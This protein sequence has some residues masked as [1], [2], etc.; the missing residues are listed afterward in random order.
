MSDT[1]VLKPNSTP[2][3][4]KKTLPSGGQGVDVDT[5]NRQMAPRPWLTIPLSRRGG[6]KRPIGVDGLT[7]E[8][9]IW[10]F[11]YSTGGLRIGQIPWKANMR[12]DLT[13][14][15]GGSYEKPVATGPCHEVKNGTPG[16]SFADAC[17]ICDEAERNGDPIK[18][19]VLRRMDPDTTTQDQ[20]RRVMQAPSLYVLPDKQFL[21]QKVD[22]ATLD[23]QI[24][25]VL[26]VKK[27][28]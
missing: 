8:D 10:I 1:Q 23:S 25:E 11:D 16:F 20:K 4:V 3:V 26:G 9:M 24:E 21:A 19:A 18:H 27:V 28:G 22:V 13:R 15:D 17:V 14:A 7:V 2:S 5:P 6:N 12:K